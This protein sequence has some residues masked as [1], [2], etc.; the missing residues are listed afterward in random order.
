VNTQTGRDNKT[1]PAQMPPPRAWRYR[2]IMLTH[3]LAH[4]G[5][6]MRAT[7]RA[8]AERGY[9]RALGTIHNDLERPMPACRVC[10]RPP[11]QLPEPA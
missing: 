1:Y 2:V 6:T 10:T 7:Q 3:E 9:R 11:P 8:L 4:S 5:L